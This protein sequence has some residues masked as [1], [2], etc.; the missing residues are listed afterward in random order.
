MNNDLLFSNAFKR[1]DQPINLT[2]D[3]KRR[4]TEKISKTCIIQFIAV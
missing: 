1:K 2:D 3:E 4:I